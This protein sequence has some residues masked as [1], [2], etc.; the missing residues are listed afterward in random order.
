[1]IS[2]FNLLEYAVLTVT[3]MIFLSV[4][5]GIFAGTSTWMRHVAVC[6][7]YF[8]NVVIGGQLG[9]TISAR[10]GVAHVDGKKWGK[11]MVMG[12]NQIEIDH[13]QLAIQG[14]IDR[15]KEVIRLLSPY[16]KRNIKTEEISPQPPTT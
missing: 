8:W 9:V 15:A 2:L 16:D 4:F 5:V 1:M 14:D 11:N 3:A 6:F 13:C 10:A 7:D 12:L